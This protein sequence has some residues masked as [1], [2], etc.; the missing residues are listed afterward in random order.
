VT[1]VTILGAG[2]LLPA[3]A[4]SSAAH[5]IEGEGFRLLLDCGSGTLHGLARHSV[6]WEGLSHVAITH[7]HSDH[8]GDLSAVLSVLRYRLAG[9]REEPLTLIGPPGFRGFLGRLGSAMGVHVLD[10]GFPLDVCELGPHDVYEQQASGLRIRAHAT[11]HTDESVA[12]RVE[13]TS[14]VVGYTG[15]TG[16]SDAVGEFLVGSS[17]LIGECALTD[18][19]ETEF[20]L[21]PSGLARIATL[22]DAKLLIVT[23]VYPPTLPADA[24]LLVG[25]HGFGGRIVP[26]EDGL[27]VRIDE[28]GLIIE[29]AVEGR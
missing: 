16:P 18:P 3:K 24:A 13:T 10:P 1:V 22:A 27:S 6:D 11:P 19:P 26:G 20:H 4:R 9:V 25:Q 2:T 12:Y 29:A 21:A 15:D 14:G 7:Y 17:V 5:L 28:R 23:H 8:V